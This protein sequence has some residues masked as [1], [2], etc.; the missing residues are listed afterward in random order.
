M[1]VRSITLNMLSSSVPRSGSSSD[2]AALARKFLAGINVY[3]PYGI[4]TFIPARNF[5]ANAAQS[6]LLPERGTDEDNIFNVMDLTFTWFVCV[7]VCVCV[8][9]PYIYTHTYTHKQEKTT[10]SR[11]APYIPLGRY[12]P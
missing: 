6:E 10:Y 5:L 8:C 9:I 7:C 4:Y 12:V 3:I 2:C 1:K 11:Q